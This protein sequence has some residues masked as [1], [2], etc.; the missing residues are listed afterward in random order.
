MKFK[1]YLQEEYETSLKP[2]HY[3]ISAL[4]IPIFVN[5]NKKELRECGF[6]VRYIID[7]SKKKIYVWNGNN[8]VHWEVAEYLVKEGIIKIQ[9]EEVLGTLDF[10]ENYCAGVGN[11]SGGLIEP[12]NLSDYFEEIL[13]DLSISGNTPDDWSWWRNEPSWLKYYFTSS[14]V[15]SIK[16]YYENELL[17]EWDDG[18]DNE[19]D[20]D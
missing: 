17:D 2:S 18:W 14:L 9:S 11:L 1:K 10:W 12:K 5:P 16:K 15:D 19:E 8:I 3:R 6:H 20:E 13:S 7:F 4:E